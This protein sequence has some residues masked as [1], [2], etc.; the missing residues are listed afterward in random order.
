M[1]LLTM[2]TLPPHIK[3]VVKPEYILHTVRCHLPEML[4]LRLDLGQSGKM[5]WDIQL[6][7]GLDLKS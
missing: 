6:M 2:L 3:M 4:L 7:T 1:S 5:C